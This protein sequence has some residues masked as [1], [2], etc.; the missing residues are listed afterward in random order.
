[1]GEVLQPAPGRRRC[2]GANS[3]FAKF[4]AFVELAPG[5]E[6]LCHN[7]EMSANASKQRKPAL[8]VGQ[9]YEFRIIKLDEFDKKVSLSRRAYEAAHNVSA[10]NGKVSSQPIETPIAEVQLASAK[11]LPKPLALRARSAGR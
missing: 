4:G 9:D 2:H 7:S 10:S 6:G 3:R 1:M 11:S 8:R 5:V